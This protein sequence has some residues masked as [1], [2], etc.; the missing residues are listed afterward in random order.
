[1]GRGFPDKRKKGFCFCLVLTG[2]R[3][4]KQN[5]ANA[6]MIKAPS[7]RELPMKSGEGACGA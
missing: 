7:G 4:G 6:A 3:L 2:E 1:M 5:V